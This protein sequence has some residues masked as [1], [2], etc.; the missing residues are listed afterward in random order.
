MK[1]VRDSAE[2]QTDT[3]VAKPVLDKQFWILHDRNQKIGNIQAVNGGY[4]LTMH[5][6][7]VNFA[8]LPVLKQH[9]NVDFLPATRSAQRRYAENIYG[10]CTNGRAYNAL[11][12]VKLRLPMFTRTNKSRSWFAA[13]W[14]ALRQQ[15]HWQVLDT[16]KV[17]LLQRYEFK[18]PFFTQEQAHE[19]V[20]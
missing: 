17:I 7:T 8:T 15:N 14:Y 12:N 19:S 10:Y 2:S 18:G 3:I 4:Q 6:N 13:G 1:T 16:P 9:V 20:Q 5:N 11:W